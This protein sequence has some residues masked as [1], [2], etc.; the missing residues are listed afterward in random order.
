V[1]D[2]GDII[3]NAWIAIEE[4][5]TPAED[6]NAANQKDNHGDSEY[7]PQR[8]NAGL[9]DH[10]YHHGNIRFHRETL[11][12]VSIGCRA[13]SVGFST[14]PEEGIATPSSEVNAQG[15]D[16]IIATS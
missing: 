6:Q 14:T 15:D 12:T 9:F 7:D 10:W 2:F 8:R 1:S 3:F 13:A 11:P 5:V 16:E 4:L